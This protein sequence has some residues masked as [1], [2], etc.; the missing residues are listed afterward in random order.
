M[1]IAW[2]DSSLSYNTIFIEEEEEEKRY[3]K[4]E[5]AKKRRKNNNI[6]EDER[7]EKVEFHAKFNLDSWMYPMYLYA[8]GKE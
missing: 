2:L 1:V 7:V 5:E 6:E 4:C 8:M 3:K